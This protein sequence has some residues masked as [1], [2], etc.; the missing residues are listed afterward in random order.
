MEYI[1]NAFDS[2][3][4]LSLKNYCLLNEQAELIKQKKT[5]SMGGIHYF[6]LLC[7]RLKIK[8]F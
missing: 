5:G 8:D 7:A 2:M 1:I 4:S 3:G 6:K